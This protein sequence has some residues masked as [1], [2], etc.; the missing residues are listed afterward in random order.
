MRLLNERWIQ[1]FGLHQPRLANRPIWIHACS[2][3]EVNSV[4]PLAEHLLSKGHAVHFTVVTE[5]GMANVHR[6]LGERVSASYLPFDLPGVMHAFV[7]RITPKILLLVETEFWPGM[8]K[9]CKRMHIP[10]VGINTRISDRSF[11]RY[12]TTAALWKR[13]LKPVSCFCAQSPLD[14][15]R[16]ARIG[17]A[18]ERIKITGNLKYAVEPP[19]VDANTLR[20]RIDPTMRRPIFLAASTHSGEEKVL[21]YAWSQWRRFASDLLFVLVPRHPERVSSVAQMLQEQ[22]IRLHRWS[23]GHNRNGDCIL[24]D[25]MGV[26]RKLYV[27]ADLV[28]IGGSL[29]PVGGH[30]P[31]EAAI[32]G[33]GVITGPHVENFRAIMLEMQKAGAAVVCRN[34]DEVYAAGKNFVLHPSEL[35]QLHGSA[36]AFMKSRRD[37]LSEVLDVIQPFLVK[38]HEAA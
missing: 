21:A 12:L 25:E 24:V 15:E 9:A 11:P 2:V 28:F 16:L 8:L 22:G 32:C 30:N 6:R 4:I 36:A 19:E 20:Q 37:V 14:A 35:R 38:A 1:L 10:V 26:L 5:T 23:D 31:L 34:A 7:R 3:G 33:R 18:P 29:V 13:W 27:V 17:V